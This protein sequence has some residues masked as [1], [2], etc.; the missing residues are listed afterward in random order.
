MRDEC[1]GHG[2]FHLFR[3]GAMPLLLNAKDSEQLEVF[4][5]L[6]LNHES[7]A[8]IWEDGRIQVYIDRDGLPAS[9]FEHIPFYYQVYV[10]ENK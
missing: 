3:V 8:N 1:D 7:W 5:N 4:P 10:A 2:C 9:L 6:H